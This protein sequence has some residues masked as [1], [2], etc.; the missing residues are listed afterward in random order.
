MKLA[1][2]FVTVSFKYTMYLYALVVFLKKMD[3][4]QTGDIKNYFPISCNGIG[5][6][7]LK[8]VVTVT[9]S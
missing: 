9:C 4:T 5:R 2:V 6:V 8:K 7:L 1:L 3:V